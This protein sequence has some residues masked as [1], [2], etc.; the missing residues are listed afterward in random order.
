MCAIMSWGAH[1]YFMHPIF[2]LKNGCDKE[3]VQCLVGTQAERSE[4]ACLA[5]G[6]AKR[7]QKL[8]FRLLVHG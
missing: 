4:G 5:Q 6:G 8:L 1:E 2:V 7:M 3:K